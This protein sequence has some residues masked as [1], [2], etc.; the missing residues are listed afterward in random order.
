MGRPDLRVVL[1]PHPIGGIPA[2]EA[3]AKAP[4]AAQ[5]IP[6]LFGS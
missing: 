6:A 2:E 3:A 5:A 1:V 4:A